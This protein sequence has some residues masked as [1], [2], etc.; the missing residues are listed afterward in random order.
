VFLIN[1][2]REH[3][4]K[5]WISSTSLA[6]AVCSFAVPAALAD[7]T[8]VAPV[9]VDPA[10]LSAAVSTD[11]T[12]LQA[13][14]QAN[15]LRIGADVAQLTSDQA[16]LPA[17]QTSEQLRT[18]LQPDLTK[19]RSDLGAAREQIR[20]DGKQLW[21]DLR[22]LKDAKVAD[23]LQ[24]LLVNVRTATQA[25]E[26]TLRSDQKLAWQATAFLGHDEQGDHAKQDSS[27]QGDTAKSGSKCDHAKQGDPAKQGSS[28]TVTSIQNGTR[29][30]FSSKHG[31]HHGSW[32]NHAH[33]HFGHHHR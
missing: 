16:A 13:D 24:P 25:A 28:T 11:I 22:P 8:P 17:G 15:H 9:T 1:T 14:T 27:V 10:A 7:G 26:Q 6:L 18:A 33:G 23:S 4:M 32:G 29:N 21:S 30:A 3:L 12:A 5:K 31:D 2:K 19:L 20:S